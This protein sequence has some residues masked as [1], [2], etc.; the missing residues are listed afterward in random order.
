[1]SDLAHVP[2]V[3]KRSDP[4]RLEIEWADGHKTRYTAAELRGLCPCARCVDELTGV[5]V[6]D[7]RA[8][9][10]DLTQTEV[11]LVGNYAL[12]VLYSDGHHTGIYTWPF[13][14]DNDPG[15]AG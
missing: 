3:I 14:R 10:P 11:K 5:R 8:V 7:P 9:P 15:D 2:R 6:H 1:M 12:T 13:L 4:A